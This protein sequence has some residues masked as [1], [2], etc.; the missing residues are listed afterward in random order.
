MGVLS[1][2]FSS[3]RDIIFQSQVP[4][5]SAVSMC[6]KSNHFKVIRMSL[7]PSTLMMILIKYERAIMETS[8]SHKSMGY[9]SYTQWRG[10]IKFLDAHGQLTP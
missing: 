1:L 9:F 5:M 3:K 7:L 10:Y 6:P 2:W 8:C 4:P